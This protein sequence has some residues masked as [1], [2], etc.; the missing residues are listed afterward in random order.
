MNEQID[1][2]AAII[3]II[4]IEHLVSSPRVLTRLILFCCVVFPFSGSDDSL[5]EVPVNSPINVL[6]LQMK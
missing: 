6:T 3:I 1:F 4:R 5:T 2:V